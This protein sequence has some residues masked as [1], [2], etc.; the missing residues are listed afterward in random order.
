MHLHTSEIHATKVINLNL[1][2]KS[3]LCLFETETMSK[4]DV[5]VHQIQKSALETISRLVGLQIITALSCSCCE[6]KKQ[7]RRKDSCEKKQKIF[8]RIQFLPGPAPLT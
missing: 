7:L 2:C 8:V 4:S 6:E 5:Y 1:P 3:F